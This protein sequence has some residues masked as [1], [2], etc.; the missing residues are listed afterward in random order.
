MIAQCIPTRWKS[1]TGYTTH[2][3]IKCVDYSH[4]AIVI[5]TSDID[6]ICWLSNFGELQHLNGF[7]M[8]DFYPR[9]CMQNVISYIENSYE[10]QQIPIVWEEVLSEIS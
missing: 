1:L 10:F 6:L 7:I 8:L 3:I 2:D 5:L 9:A 4:N